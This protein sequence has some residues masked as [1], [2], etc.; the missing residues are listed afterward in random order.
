MKKIIMLSLNRYKTF[1]VFLFS[2]ESEK[3][4]RHPFSFLFFTNDRSWACL[5]HQ[6]NLL[7]NYPLK[8]F[9]PAHSPRQIFFCPFQISFKIPRPAAYYSTVL[10]VQFGTAERKKKE[11]KIPLYIGGMGE[12]W[13]K[14]GD[15]FF[16]CP[17]CS[18]LFLLA[19][20]QT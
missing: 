17:P 3:K 7:R 6:P 18:N 13:P 5:P 20:R 14:A 1:Q 15:G 9:K 16:K 8:L 19:D 10:V 12:K 11:K 4:K 2:P